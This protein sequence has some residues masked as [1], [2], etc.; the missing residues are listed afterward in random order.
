LRRELEKANKK[1]DQQSV[2][3]EEKDTEIKELTVKYTNSL[4]TINK[5]EAELEDSTE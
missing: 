1:V 2:K 4:K 5:L 3:L